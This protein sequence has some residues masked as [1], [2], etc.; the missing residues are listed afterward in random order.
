M[1]NLILICFLKFL[2]G[3]IPGISPELSWTLTT[4]VY[5]IVRLQSSLEAPFPKKEKRNFFLIWSCGGPQRSK[6]LDLPGSLCNTQDT[7]LQTIEHGAGAENHQEHSPGLFF[8][9]FSFLA[10]S[11]DPRSEGGR[12]GEPGSRFMEHGFSRAPWHRW[13]DL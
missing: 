10:G 6:P 9:L 13:I 4:L 8:F 5:N 11:A 2:F 12:K 3:I 1:T 7:F